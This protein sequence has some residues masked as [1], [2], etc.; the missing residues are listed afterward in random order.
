MLTYSIDF[1]SDFC[2]HLKEIKYCD[3]E[4]L[5]C[6]ARDL[7]ENMKY[8]GVTMKNINKLFDD[9]RYLKNRRGKEP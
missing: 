5:F 7:K 8:D 9:R 1:E 2:L 3:L 6:D 4:T